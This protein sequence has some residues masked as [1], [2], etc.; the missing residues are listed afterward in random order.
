MKKYKKRNRSKHKVKAQ[1]SELAALFEKELSQLIDVTI[2]PNN[3]GIKYKHYLITRLPN[4]NYGLFDLR[5]NDFIDQ[6]YLKSSALMS[7][8]AYHQNL[9][10]KYS[11]IRTVDRNYWASESDIL[12]YETRIKTA[13][14]IDRY[15]ILLDKLENTR[16]KN[17]DYKD[18]I[19]KM[20][21]W[22]FV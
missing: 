8:K 22:A 5:S 10:L 6:F 4:N 9:M 16:F 7:A 12:V 20:F 18:T 19:S 15:L 21:R 2:L 14:D 1:V 11:E 17:K 13:K 3:K